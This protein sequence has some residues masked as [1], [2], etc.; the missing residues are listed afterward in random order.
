MSEEQQVTEQS[1]E[2]NVMMLETAKAQLD[3]LAKQQQLIQLAIEEHARARETV[4]QLSKGSP[5]DDILVPIGAD[6]YLH[7]KVSDKKDAIVGI[8]SGV[9]VS[10][11]PEEAEKTLDAKI[12]DLS[13][14]FK[15]VGERA[16]QTE[17]L[18]QDLTEKVQTQYST[19]QSRGQA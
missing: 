10:K 2:Q 17:A 3:G 8:G 19:L 7:A 15:S 14:A 9:S 11:T 16:A 5:G 1:L 6:S 12:D 18:I 4:K 13:R